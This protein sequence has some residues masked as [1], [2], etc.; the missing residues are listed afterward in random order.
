M[1]TKCQDN[2]D[3]FFHPFIRGVVLSG[4]ETDRVYRRSI[5]QGMV[6]TSCRT[7]G[8]FLHRKVFARRKLWE[9]GLTSARLQCRRPPLRLDAPTDSW[10][11]ER[12][13]DH[14]SGTSVTAA[15]CPPPSCEALNISKPQTSKF[16]YS[17]KKGTYQLSFV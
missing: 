16:K 13:V 12:R 10:R 5:R 8:E 6:P 1:L 4:I 11:G 9:R 14:N 7:P 15:P 3:V 2:G 17:Y